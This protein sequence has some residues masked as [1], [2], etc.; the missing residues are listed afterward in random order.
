M[1]GICTVLMIMITFMGGYNS[2]TI[3]QLGAYDRQLV[4]EGQVWRLLTLCLWS[5]E[6]FSFLP[7]YAI[8][9][10]FIPSS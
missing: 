8:Y 5:Y 10:I 1:V 6:L 2:K 7:E 4:D 9:F 3:L